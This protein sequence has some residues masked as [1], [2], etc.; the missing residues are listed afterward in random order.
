M[1]GFIVLTLLVLAVLLAPLSP[2]DPETSKISERFQPPPGSTRWAPMRLGRDLLTR[3]LYGGRISLTVGLLV[4]AIT[5]GHRC[6]DRGRW[7][8]TPAAWWITS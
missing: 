5:L 8:V 7:P 4:V 3:I 2:Y 1:A 6:D